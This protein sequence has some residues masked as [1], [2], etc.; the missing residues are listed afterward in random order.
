[1]APGRSLG[2]QNVVLEDGAHS[3]LDAGN[4]SLSYHLMHGVNTSVVGVAR[5]PLRCGTLLGSRGPD[6]RGSECSVP[7]SV[8]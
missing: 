3:S 2:E 1:M 7:F 8:A 6:D 5:C 4:K